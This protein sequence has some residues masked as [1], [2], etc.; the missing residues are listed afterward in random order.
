MALIS[1]RIIVPQDDRSIFSPRR[2]RD[3]GQLPG[4]GCQLGRNRRYTT[5]QN[6]ML[7]S[8]K[9]VGSTS[10]VAGGRVTLAILFAIFAVNFMDR[11]VVAILVEPIKRDLILS[12]TEM[13]CFMA[14]RLQRSTQLPGSRLHGLPSCGSGTDHQLVAR[15]VQ[16]DDCTLRSRDEL[17]A[18]SGS[19]N[20]DCDRRRR[21]EPAVPFHHFR[22]I[23]HQPT[24]AHPTARSLVTRRR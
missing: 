23:S 17:L 2:H 19:A 24:P 16:S 20:R 13:G 3:L 18:A 1:E 15:A 8:R 9:P 5:R 22:L 4:P 14:S 11:Q 10:P 21:H 7:G 6:R 12:D